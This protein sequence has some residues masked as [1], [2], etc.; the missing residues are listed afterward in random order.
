MAADAE[1][2]AA[3]TLWSFVRTL[4]VLVLELPALVA[5][6]LRVEMAGKTQT[7]LLN[8]NAIISCK[9]LGSSPLNI[10]NVGVIWS[11]KNPV[12]GRDVT[13]FEFYGN[14]REAFRLG[15]SVSLQGLA[16]GDASLQLPEVQLWEAGEYR[17]KVVNTPDRGQG[18]VFLEVVACPV[19]SLSLE[20]A[21]QRLLCEASG[22]YP[23]N[24]NITWCK[25][26]QENSQCVNISEN[27]TTNAAIANEDDTFNVTSSLKLKRSLEHNATY[28]CRVE[29]VFLCTPWR[30]NITLGENVSEP[31]GDSWNLLWI[32][33]PCLA[34]SVLLIVPWKRFCCPGAVDGR[35]HFTK[36]LSEEETPKAFI[37][38]C[39]G[40]SGG[41]SDGPR[42]P[43]HAISLS[44]AV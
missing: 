6:S 28:Q 41:V 3:R 12:D 25:W 34:V 36:I 44:F 2:A 13:V 24:I 37:H 15:A 5:E 30:R 38:D 31:K 26:S 16:K 39:P 9:V 11:R 19:S 7:M 35:G 14:H 32:F 18:T 4:L 29:H 21:N 43:P 17:C 23:K 27:V 10:K 33:A 20:E 1:A 22:F 8:H 40:F 42:H